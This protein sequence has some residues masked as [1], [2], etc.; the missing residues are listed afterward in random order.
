MAHT[1][2][3]QGLD[4]DREYRLL[5]ERLDRNVTG[6]PDTPAVRRILR[7][8][9]SPEDAHIARSLPQL[10]SLP[11]LAKKLDADL[12]ELDEQITSMAR[13]GPDP[14][15]RAQRHPLR[16]GRTGG[17][18]LLRVHLHAGTPGCADGG[19]RRRLRGHVRG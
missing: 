15:L 19:V 9:F 8:L 7:L 16:A 1:T 10:I 17:D 4:V 13:R 11:D 3:T 5:Q 18:R 14:R 6:A 2:L 12:D